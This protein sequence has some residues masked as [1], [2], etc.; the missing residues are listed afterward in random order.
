LL[1]E[2]DLRGSWLSL[3][4]ATGLASGALADPPPEPA[5]PEAFH[6]LERR[7][8]QFNTAKPYATAEPGHGLLN[9]SVATATRLEKDYILFARSARPEWRVAAL[10]RAAQVM[11]RLL[12]GLQE[13]RAASGTPEEMAVLA[14]PEMVR[15]RAELDDNIETAQTE[16]LRRYYLA[17]SNAKA[18]GVKSRCRQ[19]AEAALEPC[20]DCSSD[21][22][23]LVGGRCV[24]DEDC[25]GLCIHGTC[26]SRDTE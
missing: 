8:G 2:G 1:K 21:G 13:A 10:C 17:A 3:V 25:G 24:K 12:S 6:T 22:N 11:D 20:D 4:L 16:S 5:E 19:I 26:V 23:R 15:Y 7:F 18:L 9:R 14:I